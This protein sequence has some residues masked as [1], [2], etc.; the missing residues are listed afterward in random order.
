MELPLR[1]NIST[2]KSITLHQHLH[3]TVHMVPAPMRAVTSVAVSSPRANNC[4]LHTIEEGRRSEKSSVPPPGC[5]RF[6]HT[7][8]S[9]NPSQMSS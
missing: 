6:D 7:A 5:Y 4:Q 2:L 1:A 8:P 9:A 3:A